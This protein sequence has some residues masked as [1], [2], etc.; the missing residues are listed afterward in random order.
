MAFYTT[1]KESTFTPAPAGLHGATC[2]DII[3]LGM[4]SGRYGSYHACKIVWMIDKFNQDFGDHF[5]V[6]ARYSVELTPKGALTKMLT[7]WKGG[8]LSSLNIDLELMIGCTCSINI[9]HNQDGDNL[10]ANVQAVNPYNEALPLPNT[11]KYVRHINRDPDKSQ[12]VR[13]TGQH[14]V[15]AQ[16]QQQAWNAN[17]AGGDSAPAQPVAGAEEDLADLPF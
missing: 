4:V 9:V 3:D 11:E 14:G 5:T 17:Q 7:S 13:V 16:A 1:K 12:D 6:S 10:W 2:V 15:P 8:A